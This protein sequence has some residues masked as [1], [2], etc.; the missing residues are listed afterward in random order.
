MPNP[1]RKTYRTIDPAK[2][3]EL[4]KALTVLPES[5]NPELSKTDV[6]RQ[7]RAEIDAARA[8]GYTFNKIGEILSDKAGVKISGRAIQI[9]LS[10]KGASDKEV[11]A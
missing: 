10:K 1:E 7:L 2:V 8:K 11:T 3:K 5:R 4:K 9:A 6:I